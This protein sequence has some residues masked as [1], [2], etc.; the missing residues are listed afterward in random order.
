MVLLCVGVLLVGLTLRGSADSYQVTAEVL[1]PLPTMPATIT[2]PADQTHFTSEPISVTGTC[3]ENTY[4]NLYRNNVF[5]GTAICGSGQTSFQIDTD[6]FPGSNVLTAQVFNITDQAGPTSSSVTV[7]YDNP[8]EPPA[9]VPV[10]QPLGLQVTA[11]DNVTFN[12]NAMTH[13]SPYVTERGTAPPY[14]HIVVTFHSKPLTCET[15]ADSNGNWSCTLDQPLAAGLH[16]VYVV[17]TTPEGNT[18]TIKSF[19]IYVSAAVAPLQ[20]AES[21]KPLFFVIYNYQYQPLVSGQSFSL[22][23]GLDGGT[24]PYAVTVLW[25]DGGES[26]VARNNQSKFPVSHTYTLLGRSQQTYRI[27]VEVADSS[28]LTAFLEIPE[29]VRGGSSTVSPVVSG[30]NGTPNGQWIQFA[31]PVYGVTMLM[32]LSFWLGER[33]EYYNLFSRKSARYRR[34]A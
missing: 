30:T 20:P 28:G 2:S 31:W 24:S 21:S 9:P 25:G 19:Q 13:V 15:D 11:Q 12:K 23:L 32:V 6:L 27:K 26:T 10:T 16:T 34:R 18:L 17:A 1:A 14:S 22:D 29:L 4:V 8:V 7:W 3:P 5:S 33:Q